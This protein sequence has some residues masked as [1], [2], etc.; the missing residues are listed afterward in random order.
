[1]CRRLSE[2]TAN[3]L[4]NVKQMT[5]T[6]LQHAIEK[7]GSMEIEVDIHAP[8]IIVPYGGVYTGNENVLVI[9]LG[10]LKLST[11]P[12]SLS[13][14][15]VRTLHDSGTDETDILHQM[16]DQSYDKFDIVFTDLQVVL[17]QSGEDWKHCLNLSQET[18]LHILNPLTLKVTLEKCLITDDP[19][20]PLIKIKGELP[21]ISLKI[22]NSKL[23]LLMTLI[24][25][26]PFPENETAALPPKASDS[27]VTIQ[28][29]VYTSRLLI[30]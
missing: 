5:A 16:I 14:V 23:I 6:G 8:Y 25:S 27:V 2:A 13:K 17:A 18:P 4:N 30:H 24:S 10:R 12:R 22:V 20:L 3:S 28:T 1:M 29:K 7:H 19:R 9:N 15:N 26:I 21:S 11:T